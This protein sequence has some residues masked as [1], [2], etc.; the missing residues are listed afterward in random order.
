[1]TARARLVRRGGGARPRGDL[2][3]HLRRALRRWPAAGR[4]AGRARLAQAGRPSRRGAI[5]RP[6][7]RHAARAGLRRRAAQAEDRPG[8][9][10][11]VSPAVWAYEVSGKQVLTSGSA[12]S[13]QPGASERRSAIVARRRSSA[14]SSPKV[15]A[16][17]HDRAVECAPRPDWLVALEP[18]QDDLLRRIVEGP[19]IS[20]DVLGGAGALTDSSA[21]ASA[22]EPEG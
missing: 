22:A 8:Y 1:M 20:A 13:P 21:E 15:V 14:I 18:K 10:A 6:A 4:A 5:L 17:V 3:A 2:A 11:N 7:R 19:T 12:I 16:R 9:I